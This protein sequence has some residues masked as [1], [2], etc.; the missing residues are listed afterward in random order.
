MAKAPQAK[1]PKGGIKS[2]HNVTNASASKPIK[3]GKI[4]LMSSTQFPL[5]LFTFME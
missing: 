5:L 1:S 3:N 2:V 4:P